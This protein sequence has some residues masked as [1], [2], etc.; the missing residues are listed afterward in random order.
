M[1]TN[2]R[3]LVLVSGQDGST[4]ISGIMAGRHRHLPATSQE[5]RE[6]I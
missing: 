2:I 3:R 1:A 6:V 4:L 5:H